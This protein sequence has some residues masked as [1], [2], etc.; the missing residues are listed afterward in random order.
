LRDL[1]ER[2]VATLARET[3]AEGGGPRQ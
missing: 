1:I 3:T 2:I